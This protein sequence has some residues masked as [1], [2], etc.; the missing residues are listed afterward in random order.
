MWEVGAVVIDVLGD[1]GRRHHHRRGTQLSPTTWV[2]WASSFCWPVVGVSKHNDNFIQATAHKIVSKYTMKVLYQLTYHFTGISVH[3]GAGE[4][5]A[6][7]VVVTLAVFGNILYRCTWVP[8][9]IYDFILL[10]FRP[11]T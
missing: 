10:K 9:T 11:N 1:M 6:T 3:I 8:I 7:M 5:E 2:R 4:E